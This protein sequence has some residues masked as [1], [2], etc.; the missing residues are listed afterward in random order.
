MQT[1]QSLGEFIHSYSTEEVFN[2]WRRTEQ[3]L[4]HWE[5]IWKPRGSWEAWRRETHRL[6]L[7]ANLT[8]NGYRLDQPLETVPTWRGGLFHAWA[9][10]F[11]PTVEIPESDSIR[12]N[13]VN[14]PPRLR[15]LL[16]HPGVSNHYYI[17]QIPEAMTR[18]SWIQTT[19]TALRHPNGEISVV[20]GMHR[21]CGI[22]AATKDHRPVF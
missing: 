15:D 12:K 14:L 11:Y 9:K 13:N 3:K 10:Y 8:W 4:K 6:V 17:R 20:E 1:D 21:S 19:L 18:G 2:V 5:P 16:R 22:A 7:E